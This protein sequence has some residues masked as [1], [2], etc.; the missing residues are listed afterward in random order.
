LD[1]IGPAP[2]C[3]PALSVSSDGPALIVRDPEVL[4][5]FQLERVL[6][7]LVERASHGGMAPEE[8]LQRLFDTENTTAAGRFA[9][10]AHCDSAGN[11]AFKNG[12]AV[13]CPRAEAAL[14]T[15]SGMFTPG[16]PDYFVPVA[17]VNRFDLTTLGSPS[18]GEYRMVFAK[19]SGRS[20]PNDRLF[21][22]FE[23]ALRNP[24]PGQV[25]GCYP[26]AE[27]WASLEKAQDVSTKIALLEQFYF[28]GLQG[29]E[30]LVDPDHFSPN[31]NDSMYGDSRGQVRVSQR[32]QAPWELREL[33]IATGILSKDEP[34]VF[35]VPVTVKNNPLPSLFDPAAAG[36]EFAD[37]FEDTFVDG[38]EPARLAGSTVPDIRMHIF[39]QFNAGE[40]ALEGPAQVNYMTLALGGDSST[41]LVDA[42]AER[43]AT[44]PVDLDAS[45]PPDD[46]LTAQSI[47]SRAT[48][49]TCAGC[50]SPDRFLGPERKIGCGLTWPSTLG[51]VH[52]DENG[53]LSPA[54]TDVFL[55]HRARVMTTF[56]QACDLP[57]IKANLQPN[58]PE[59]VPK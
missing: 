43:L 36:T 27:H 1:P 59:L 28:D 50:H 23:G 39:P 18:C 41:P 35:F 20:N 53:A 49:L 26:V 15:S 9:N 48:A 52:I 12:P 58:P 55:P 29:F 3:N 40:S 32:M 47:L 14:A 56:L 34:P 5:P 17:L 37:L 4:A 45:C 54:L 31:A 30:P 57:A 25:M 33:H 51:Q 21:L 22:I 8:L 16:H 6:A 46:P 38:I 42:I 2:A 11:A 7:Q 24:T 19:W 44:S 10:N 13:D